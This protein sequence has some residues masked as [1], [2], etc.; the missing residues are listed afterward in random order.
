MLAAIIICGTHHTQIARQMS[1]MIP[2]IAP[3]TG[4]PA[5]R[6]KINISMKTYG[7]I[8]GAIAQVTVFT[9]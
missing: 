1:T 7:D 4:I 9:Y 5:C 6:N 2:M 8:I 3:K